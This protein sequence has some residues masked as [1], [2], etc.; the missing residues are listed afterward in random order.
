MVREKARKICGMILLVTLGI[1]CLPTAGLAFLTAREQVLNQAAMGENTSTVE[2][3][4]QEPEPL[5]PEKSHEIQKEIRVKNHETIPCY[6]RV[7]ILQG[8]TDTLCTWKDLDYRLWQKR[9]E[10]YYYTQLVNPGES[11]EPLAGTLILERSGEP[12]GQEFQ[13]LVYEES[14]QA[15]NPESGKNWQWLD[16]WM[17]YVGREGGVL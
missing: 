3:K 8:D 15:F 10:Y 12:I 2:E 16:A 17:Y 6:V 14:V 7:R 13:L 1:L 5:D 9:G 4:F 11:T